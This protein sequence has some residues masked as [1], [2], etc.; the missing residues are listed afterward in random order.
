M[1]AICHENSPPSAFDCGQSAL[2]RRRALRSLGF[3]DRRH[4]QDRPVRQPHI[5]APVD[6]QLDGCATGADYLL[7][8]PTMLDRLVRRSA[9]IAS[10]RSA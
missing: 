5:T 3:L 7:T 9:E 8:H 4:L 1:A 10:G 2:S 6:D